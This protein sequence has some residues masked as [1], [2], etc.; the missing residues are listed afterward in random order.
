MQDPTPV[1]SLHP[2]T[3]F[4]YHPTL[5]QTPGASVVLFSSPECGSC[6]TVERL[7]PEAAAGAV[8]TLYKVDVQQ[9]TALAREF[10]IFHLPTLFL[11]RDGRFHAVVQ[12]EVTPGKLQRAIAAALAAPPEEEP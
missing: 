4:N 6:R 9:A 7:L 12:S 11:Y 1:L 8:T 2:L 5:A 3:E 10:E